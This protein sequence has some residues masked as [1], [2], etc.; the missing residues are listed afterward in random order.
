MRTVSLHLIFEVQILRARPRGEES[1]RFGNDNK[2][3]AYTMHD[4][5]VWEWNMRTAPEWTDSRWN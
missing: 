2:S 1:K 5:Y 4:I 3:E